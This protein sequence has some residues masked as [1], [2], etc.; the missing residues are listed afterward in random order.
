[1]N[2]FADQLPQMG[3][4]LFLTDGGI[5]TTMIFH[6]GVD[7][8]EFAVFVMLD[9]GKNADTLRNYYRRYLDILEAGFADAGSPAPRAEALALM[10]MGEGSALFLD[11][12]RRWSRDAKAVR[13][14]VYGIICA[15]YPEGKKTDA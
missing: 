8:P 12:G 13:D 9:N 1:M 14:V 4:K 2:N 3:D 10:S 11:P 7:L 5:E 6:E 15:R